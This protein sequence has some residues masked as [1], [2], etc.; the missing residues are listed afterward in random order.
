MSAPAEPIELHG[1]PGVRIA[2]PDGARADICLHGAQVLSWIP[3]RAEER[4][5]LSERARFGEDA[6]IRGGIPVVF[7]RFGREGAL[8]QHGFARILPW[9]LAEARGGRDFAAVT[10][11]LEDNADTRPL[12]PHP[13]H[14]ELTVA[15]GANRLDIELEVENPC[16]EPFTFTAA[17]HTYLRVEEVEHARLQGLTG[18]R[19]R[20]QA[21][22]V[23]ALDAMP[24]LVVDDETD[25]IY[26]DTPNVLHLRDG[27]RLTAI[28]AEGFPDVVVW[29]PWETKQLP[30]LPANGF[31]R[32][33]C[34]EAAVI[35]RP[36]LL[37]PGEAWWGRQSLVALR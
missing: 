33:L 30:D 20:D 13:F 14:A 29:N 28:H 16:G 10:L 32:M 1:L 18:T 8:P 25:R 34:V 36:V 9:R 6:A 11:E 21:R 31:R 4:L 22:R 12:W 7:P 24:A 2:A 37:E 26:W 35:G 5:Y 17:L 27:P 15:V 19:Y 23:E 3:P